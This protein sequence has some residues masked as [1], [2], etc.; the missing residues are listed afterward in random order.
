MQETQKKDIRNLM[1]SAEFDLRSGKDLLRVSVPCTEGLQ[2][3]IRHV[4]RNCEEVLELINMEKVTQPDLFENARPIMLDLDDP[5]ALV[6]GRV[7]YTENGAE[8]GDEVNV[9]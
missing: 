3:R 4:I 8:P 5:E 7:V 1:Q 6:T 2:C 9:N